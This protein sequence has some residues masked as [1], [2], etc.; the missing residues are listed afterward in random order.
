MADGIKIEFDQNM[1]ANIER[2]L[3]NMR[4]QAPKVLKMAINDTARKAR[5]D[6]GKKA[7]ETYAV[8]VKGLASKIRIQAATAGSLEAIL[9]V[10]GEALPLAQ[11]YFK[12]QGGNGPKCPHMVTTVNKTEGSHTWGPRAFQAPGK[13]WTAEYPHP[14]PKKRHKTQ[15]GRLPVKSLRTV[16]VPQMIGNEKQVYGIVEPKIQENLRN[17]VNRHIE[18]VL[19][20]G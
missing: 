9:R 12:V 2:R 5:E 6:L 20:G 16:S 14:N 15:K 11:R 1:L 19:S 13:V 7:Q 8:K 17:S 3:G 18:R 4:S 10:N